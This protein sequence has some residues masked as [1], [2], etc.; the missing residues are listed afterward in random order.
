MI[1]LMR[2]NSQ[3]P[4]FINL[5]NLLD[6]E[7]AIRDGDEHSFYN[8]FN[9]ISQIKYAIVAYENNKSI[10]CGAIKEFSKEAMEVKRM[11][12][13]PDKRG[14]GYAAVILRGLEEWA[15]ALGYP[16]SILETGK[17]QPEAIKLY[18]KNGYEQIPNYGQYSGVENS[19]CFMK[20]LIKQT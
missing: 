8:Q 12:V 19:K 3:D 13:L 2:T 9:S 17:K 6:S 4:H 16:K 11:F 10:G 18:L 5:V 15:L 14:K 20:D 1:H 7:L